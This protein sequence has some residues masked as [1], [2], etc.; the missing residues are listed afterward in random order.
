MQI[1]FTHHFWDRWE[2]RKEDLLSFGI[3]PEKIKEYVI[4]PD[5]IITDPNHEHREWR[6]KKIQGRCLKIVVERR[7]IKLEIVT[8]FFDRTLKRKGLC[9]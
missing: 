8:V 2:K 4:N 1:I 9:E 7:G 3:T 6:I 5:L